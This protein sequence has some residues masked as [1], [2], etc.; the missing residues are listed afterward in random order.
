MGKSYEQRRLEKLAS[1][2]LLDGQSGRVFDDVVKIAAQLCAAPIAFW[3]QTICHRDVLVV[4]DMSEDPRF[5]G[6]PVLTGVPGLR[7]Y[8]GFPL[9]TR[10]GSCMGTLCVLDTVPR[11]L[12]SE[13][14]EATHAL[15][16]QTMSVLEMRSMMAEAELDQ[17]QAKHD[18]ER[19]FETTR[20]IGVGIYNLDKDGK[21]TFVND[22]FCRHMGLKRDQALGYGFMSTVLEPDRFDLFEKAQAA[23][24]ARK[25]FHGTWRVQRED[26]S[27]RHIECFSEPDYK[28]GRVGVTYDVT[29]YVDRISTLEKEVQ[30]LRAPVLKKA[31]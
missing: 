17:L 10:D 28:G 15:V 2:N 7:F 26:G 30:Q 8:A 12:T 5:K 1:L 27:L 9:W 18:R 4:E 11:T 14:F 31:E 3:D 16:R 13:Q 22:S 23:R 6:N 20:V 29:E 21:C 24:I 19:L 25:G